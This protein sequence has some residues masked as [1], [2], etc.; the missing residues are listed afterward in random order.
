[1]GIS[2]YLS[3]FALGITPEGLLSPTYGGTGT[4]TGGGNSPTI[5]SIGYIGDDTATNTAGGGSVTINGTN[6]A[7]GVTV[8]IGDVQVSQVSLVSSTQLTFVAPANVAGSYILYVVNTDGGVA[9]SVSGIQYSGVPSWTTAAGSLGTPNASTSFTTTLA[10]TGDA[11][12]SYSVVSGELPAGISLNSSTGVISGTTPNISTSTTYNF[13][14]RASDAQN[15]DTSRAFSLGVIAVPLAPSIIGEPWG[16][17]YY[18]G[19][20]STSGNGVATHYLIVAPKSTE[21]FG[22]TF[23]SGTANN[24]SSDIDGPTNTAN[25]AIQG[26][27]A[28]QYCQDLVTGGYSD[29]YLPSKNELETIYYFLKPTEGNNTGYQA[30]ATHTNAVSPEPLN[31]A[32]TSTVPGRTTALA[33]RQ[34]GGQHFEPS[35]GTPNYPYWCSTDHW[36]D[37]RVQRFDSGNQEVYPRGL[38]AWTRAVRR[39]PV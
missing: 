9:I 5:T 33:F 6:F 17:G 39:I 32:Y 15:Q 14:V 11:P 26:S 27:N 30:G 4:T 28:A 10:A 31:T 19:K 23:T 24:A 7:T 34:G 1:M 3:K 36:S 18:A 25:H 12:I 16:G 29:W 20:I 21:V 13:T 22:K 8:L 35:A 38:G 37:A 2:S